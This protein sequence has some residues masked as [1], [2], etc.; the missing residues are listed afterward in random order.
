M[1][2]NDNDDSDIDGDSDL[3]SDEPICLH[4][5]SQRKTPEFPSDGNVIQ[6]MLVI[7]QM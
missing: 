5:R 3:S 7:D 2:D 6:M 4:T 1:N